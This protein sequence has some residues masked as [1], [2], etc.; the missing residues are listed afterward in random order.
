MEIRTSYHTHNTFCDG[1]ASIEAM[2]EAAVAA[3]LLEFGI[4]S[5]APLPFPCEWTMPSARLGEYVEHVRAV[6]A[7]YRDRITVR[8]GL[9]LDYIPAPEVVAFQEREVLTQP[10]DYLIGSVHFLGAGYPPQSFDDSAEDFARI[11]AAEYGGDIRAMA[12][13]FYRRVRAMV[14][15]PHITIVGHLDRIKRFN[16]GNAFF[17]A[18]EPWY[19]AE[20]EMT[21]DAI[22]ASGK[23]V[24]LNT[25]G[26]RTIPGDAYPE[27]AI[28]EGCKTRG[29]PVILSSDAHATD[30][31]IWGFDR[32]AALLAELDIEPLERL[33]LEA[34][35][36]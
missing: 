9:E 1:E 14:E 34:V 20:V 25:A 27:R 3:E 11:L 26:W 12:A 19:R 15:L 10:L 5:H 32:G 22:A 28:L 6:A 4:S 17:S 13:E 29:I 18:E 36:G 30:E 23:I 8:L 7:E 21:L 24:E 33:P 16:A 31:V 2:V 35:A